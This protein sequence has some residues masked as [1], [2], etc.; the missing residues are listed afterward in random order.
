MEATEQM[1]IALEAV[2]S[3]INK[4]VVALENF[5]AGLGA[6]YKRLTID[7]SK[8]TKGDAGRL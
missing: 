2:P 1:R 5:S 6:A 3:R 7:S 8:T 4:T